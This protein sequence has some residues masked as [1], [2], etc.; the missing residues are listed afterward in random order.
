MDI[1]RQRQLL[2]E[3]QA[4]LGEVR[5]FNTWRKYAG[6]TVGVP[7]ELDVLHALTDAHA[8]LEH[9]HSVLG[10]V[11][12]GRKYINAVRRLVGAVD[13]KLVFAV[14]VEVH[15]QRPGP[16]A[17][18]E[19]HDQPGVVIFETLEATVL[20]LPSRR[21]GPSGSLHGTGDNLG[22]VDDRMLR[23]LTLPGIRNMHEPV[24][25]LDDGRVTEFGLRLIL[26][27]HRRLPD[28]TVLA[29]R[30]IE[31]TAS[32]GGVVINQ[33]MTSVL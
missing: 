27:H 5:I 28:D 14:T 6:L 4:G 25:G 3:L 9:R 13:D 1:R 22:R 19:I 20:G 26:E 10:G 16:E 18:A 7:A 23:E 24:G 12:T 17:D 31:R 8:W 33:E 2:T 32:L 29:D 11:H 21:L 30:K 15:G